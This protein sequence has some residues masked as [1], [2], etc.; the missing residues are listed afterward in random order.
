VTPLAVTEGGGLASFRVRA[1]PRAKESSVQA[2]EDGVLVVRLAAPPVDGKANEALRDLL[3]EQLGVRRSAVRILAGEK[4]RHKTVEISGLGAAKVCER[5]D[6]N[7]AHLS[8]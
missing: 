6:A 7:R 4:S 3:A 1:I 2:V 5:L 8:P